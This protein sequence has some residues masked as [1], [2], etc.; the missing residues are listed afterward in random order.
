L[1]DKILANYIAQTSELN[2][3]SEPSNKNKKK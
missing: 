1:V 3:K 2:M